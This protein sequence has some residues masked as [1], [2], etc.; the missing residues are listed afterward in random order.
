[1]RSVPHHAFSARGVRPGIV[2]RTEVHRYLRRQRTHAPKNAET[3]NRQRETWDPSRRVVAHALERTLP[4]CWGPSL[5]AAAENARAEERRNGQ[6]A[7]GNGQPATSDPRR[8]RPH[9]TR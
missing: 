9:R 2:V 3:G 8:I 6:R 5:W 7:T 4:P 1:M